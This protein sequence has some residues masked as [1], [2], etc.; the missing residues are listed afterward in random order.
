MNSLYYAEYR[1]RFHP[2]HSGAAPLVRKEVRLAIDGTV[3]LLDDFQNYYLP[4]TRPQTQ[5]DVAQLQ[6]TKHQAYRV[7]LDHQWEL[8]HSHAKYQIYTDEYFHRRKKFLSHLLARFDSVREFA[9]QVIRNLRLH[10]VLL[11]QWEDAGFVL[12]NLLYLGQ[13]EERN[14]PLAFLQDNLRRHYCEVLLHAHPDEDV[15]LLCGEGVFFHYLE[16]R[17]FSGPRLQWKKGRRVISPSG[18]SLAPSKANKEDVESWERY[19]ELLREAQ[20]C[21]IDTYLEP[22]YRRIFDRFHTCAPR[23]FLCHALRLTEIVDRE[24]SLTDAFENQ[25]NTYRQRLEIADGL[26]HS[27]TLQVAV[28]PE[29]IRAAVDAKMRELVPKMETR[30]I[31]CVT[32]YL[33]VHGLDD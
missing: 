14:V 27:L 19:N 10:H 29:E 5:I 26:P 23:L 2:R 9:E 33:R 30:V 25:Q 15:G 11:S 12:Q 4:C 31:Q 22:S 24:C 32:D 17:G 1:L 3:D 6:P 18:W 16:S 13:K 28:S 7:L 20:A 8:K 21:S